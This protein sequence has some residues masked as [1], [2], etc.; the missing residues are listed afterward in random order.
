MTPRSTSLTA[1]A[2]G[3]VLVLSGCATSGPAMAPKMADF[4]QA[5]LPAAVQVPAGHRVAFETA[6]AG[7]I[8]YQ[9]QAKKDMAGQYEWVFMSPDAGLKG[10]KGERLGKYYG[11]PATWDFNDG[12]KVSGAQLAVAPNGGG[13]IPLQLVKANP[14][15]GSGMAQ[16][17]SHIQRVATKG[18]VAPAAPCDAAAMGSKRVVT[19]SADYIFW[20]PA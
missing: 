10:R 3:A 18:G 7:D 20:K 17:V 5:S 2:T 4:S 9:C 8:T 19:Y 11:P 6:A 16:G 12:S 15:M 14:A 13:N 1:L